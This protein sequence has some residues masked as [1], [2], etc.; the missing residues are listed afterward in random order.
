MADV[1][2]AAPHHVDGVE[3]DPYK[4]YTVDDEKKAYNSSSD[5]L[6]DD[7]SSDR[8]AQAGVKAMEAI[9]VSWTKWSI[10]TAYIA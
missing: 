5:G 6:A 4:D 8:E 3:K 7:S 9:S 10:I 1:T 2:T